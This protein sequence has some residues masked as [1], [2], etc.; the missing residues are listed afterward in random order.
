MID[1]KIFKKRVTYL[2]PTTINDNLGLALLGSLTPYFCTHCGMQKSIAS[3]RRSVERRRGNNSD[4]PTLNGGYLVVGDFFKFA[5]GY[6]V[7]V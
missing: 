4:P 5:F 2:F 3:T 1:P 7:T 6:A